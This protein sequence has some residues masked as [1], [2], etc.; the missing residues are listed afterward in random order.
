MSSDDVNT[1]IYV[2]M[3]AEESSELAMGAGGV[4][5]GG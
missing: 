1:Y 3:H 4:L 2:Q 5:L